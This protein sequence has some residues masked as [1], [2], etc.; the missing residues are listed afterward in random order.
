MVTLYVVAFMYS[1][2]YHESIMV[3]LPYSSS[4]NLIEFCV[5]KIYYVRIA[6]HIFSYIFQLTKT[7]RGI[8]KCL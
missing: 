3:I 1:L 2:L 5:L 7:L 4:V 8:F 6:L